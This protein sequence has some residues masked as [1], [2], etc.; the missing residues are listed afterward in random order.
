MSA[1]SIRVCDHPTQFRASCLAW[2]GGLDGTDLGPAWDEKCVYKVCPENPSPAS[3]V[4]HPHTKDPG[5]GVRSAS[6]LQCGPDPDRLS[7][8]NGKP[9][10]EVGQQER[11]G[12]ALRRGTASS[13][14]LMV[15]ALPP[16]P[17]LWPLV[18][19]YIF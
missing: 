12:G 16:C 11:H 7:Q 18:W 13:C 8:G 6:G 1:L 17:A 14:S 5:V 19:S 2:T 4:R 9:A 10:D 3:H 15:S